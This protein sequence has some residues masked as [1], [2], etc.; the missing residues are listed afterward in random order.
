[1]KKAI[2]ALVAAFTVLVAATGA[3]AATTLGA[4]ASTSTSTSPSQWVYGPY[5]VNGVYH[6]GW[7][8]VSAPVPSPSPSP[9]PSPVP[10]ATIGVGVQLL[11]GAYPAPSYMQ[12]TIPR[13]GSK[14]YHIKVTNAGT[15]NE[16]IALFP[17]AALGIWSGG[18]SAK[19]QSALTSWNH[20][21]PATVTLA[22]GQSGTFTDTIS[23]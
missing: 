15:A 21:S 14:A 19:P 20:I 11:D 22:P 3:V 17:T 2:M 18:P 8:Y 4:S 5:Y 23:V 9:S 16:T 6:Y 13:G 7:H 10:T 1:M 12:T